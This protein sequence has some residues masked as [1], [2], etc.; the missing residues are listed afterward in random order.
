MVSDDEDI[1]WVDVPPDPK[2]TRNIIQIAIWDRGDNSPMIYSLCSDGT[3]WRAVDR[4][5]D[6]EPFPASWIE[7]PLSPIPQDEEEK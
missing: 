3:I 2:P 4:S 5:F 6:I 1:V 7:I